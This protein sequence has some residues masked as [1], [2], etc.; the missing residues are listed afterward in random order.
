MNCTGIVLVNTKTTFETIDTSPFALTSSEGIL[1]R[2]SA[3]EYVATPSTGPRRGMTLSKLAW[4]TR[5]S[6]EGT[7]LKF[8]AIKSE[9][10]SISTDV[11]SSP[12]LVSNKFG[13]ALRRSTI[14]V[15]YTHLTLPTIYSV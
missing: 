1:K 4:I 6:P 13:A 9:P 12:E 7:T 2:P 15:S 11:I 14:S 10:L 8:R 3:L 5:A